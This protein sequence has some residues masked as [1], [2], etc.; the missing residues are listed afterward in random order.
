[1]KKFFYLTFITVMIIGGGLVSNANKIFAD[2]KITSTYIA[3][4]E[5]NDETGNATTTEVAE[6]ALI[7]EAPQPSRPGYTFIG[8]AK[9]FNSDGSPVLW[10]F[11]KDIMPGNNITLWA[12]Y[13][14]SY[15]ANFEYNDETGNATTTEVAEGALI[16]E[17]PQPSRPGYTFIGWAKAFNSD[18]SPV[19]WDFSKDIMPGNNIT[20]WAAYQKSYI[21]NFEYND[22]TG[23]ATTTEVAEGA[24]IP[25]APQPSRPGYTFIGWAKA[26][27]SDG[28]PVLWDFSK[29]IMPGNNITLWA[30]YQ[31]ESVVEKMGYVTLNYFDI[32]TSQKIMTSKELSGKVGVEF[33]ISPDKISGYTFISDKSSKLTGFYAK[34]KQ[35]INLYYIRNKDKTEDSIKLNQKIDD[36]SKPNKSKAVKSTNLAKN[37]QEK[38]YKLPATGE[39]NSLMYMWTGLSLILFT[40]LIV[41]VKR[42]V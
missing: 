38:S 23:N 29:D 7:P 32:S 33:I 19:L 6:G 3:N 10:D 14:K 31:R 36:E 18:G 21:A 9:A 35:T 15:I 13:Q 37:L 22:E 4:F 17:A 40:I 39:N 27:N 26:F 2:T 8:W 28:S 25:E 20:L 11:S 42:K 41:A 16:P 12:A 30:A 24:L 5:Y 1:M 34:N